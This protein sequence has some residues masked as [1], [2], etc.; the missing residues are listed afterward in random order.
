M[1]VSKSSLWIAISLSDIKSSL[2]T[3][4][5]KIKINVAKELTLEEA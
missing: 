2:S 3:L 4:S 5:I 1:S